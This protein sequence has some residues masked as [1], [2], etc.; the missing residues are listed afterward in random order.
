MKGRAA[1]VTFTA[2]KKFTSNCFF[3]SES[4]VNST[5][6]EM[7]KPAQLTKM[8]SCPASLMRAE[9]APFTAVSSVTSA[10]REV[11]PGISAGRR[12]RV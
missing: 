1:F 5:A 10:V 4:S 9:T 12:L 2:P 7:P 6:P 8:S 3:A 11:I